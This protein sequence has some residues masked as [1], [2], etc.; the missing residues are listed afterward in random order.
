MSQ[1]IQLCLPYPH[2]IVFHNGIIA[3]ILWRYLNSAIAML[4]GTSFGLPIPTV[5]NQAPINY[6][7]D[8]YGLWVYPSNTTKPT[9]WYMTINRAL[10][11]W[12]NWINKIF[13]QKQYIKY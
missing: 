13:F 7:F 3:Y 1:I 8:Q 12:I 5:V 9:V 4:N 2:W 10:F 6:Q 11:F